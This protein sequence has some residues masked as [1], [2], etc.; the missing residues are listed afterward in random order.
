M[1]LS[2]SQNNQS[3]CDFILLVDAELHKL[4]VSCLRREF[5]ASHLVRSS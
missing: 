5:D 1:T 2:A 4:V 3:L